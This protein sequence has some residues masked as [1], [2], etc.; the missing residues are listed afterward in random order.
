M[1]K[2]LLKEGERAEYGRYS[3]RHSL[4][5]WVATATGGAVLVP[6]VFLTHGHDIPG[7]NAART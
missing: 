7:A 3:S 2:V 5:N 6:T 1:I 4:R